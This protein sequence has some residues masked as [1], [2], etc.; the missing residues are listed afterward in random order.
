MKTKFILHGGFKPGSKQEDNL[1]FK[2][3][4]KGVIDNPK[5]LLVYF[6]KEA[7]RIATNKGED[8]AQFERNKEGKKLS[9]EVADEAIFSEQAQRADIVYLHGG[10]TLKLLNTLKKF[11]NTEELFK[12]KTIAADSAGVNAISEFSYSQSA[13][14]ILEGIGLIPFKTICHYSEKYKDKI[15]EL[16]KYDKNLEFL[17]LP[18]YQYKVFQK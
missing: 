14:A 12:G 10:N 9:F 1:F 17:L 2:E 6:A 3:I 18:E 16:N 5:I 15:D 4:L 11:S 13:N 8:I 7:D